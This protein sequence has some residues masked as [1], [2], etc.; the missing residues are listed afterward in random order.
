M[1]LQAVGL[2]ESLPTLAT[3]VVA[4]PFRAVVAEFVQ[5]G[6]KAVATLD[7]QIG[8]VFTLPQPV[9]G[10]ERGCPERPPT[11]RAVVGLQPAVDPL[12]LHEDGV[13][14]EAFVTFGALEHPRL[15]P[16]AGRG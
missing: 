11:L 1:L 3:V 8:C 15:L 13:I 9:T 2:L 4:A 5:R 14:L 16:S 6:G 7:A 12:V 10:Q